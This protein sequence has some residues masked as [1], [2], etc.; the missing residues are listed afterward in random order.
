MKNQK[1]EIEVIER[2]E[3]L[4]SIPTIPRVILEIEEIIDKDTTTAK[5]IEKIIKKDMALSTKILKFV[6]S[7][8][9]GFGGRI[10]NISHAIVLLGFPLVKW[11]SLSLSVFELF[12]KDMEELWEHSF[13][14]ASISEI[15]GQSIGIDEKDGLPLAALLHDVG[16]AIICATL[17]D[18][19]KR[20][21]DL[22]KKEDLFWE[23]AEREVL[24]ISHVEV[25]AVLA[26]KWGFNEMIIEGISFHHNPNPSV[27]TYKKEVCAVHLADILATALGFGDKVQRISKNCVGENGIFSIDALD[28]IMSKVI[29]RIEKFKSAKDD[30]FK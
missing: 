14:V 9:F 8:L 18:E 25:G 4:S 11:I 20:I 3:K 13:V 27:A 24:G 22:S 10:R 23:E 2:I 30:L 5:D 16:K 28:K 29:E 6:N 21:E 15:L 17:K 26:R 19:F 7:P 1:K 12:L